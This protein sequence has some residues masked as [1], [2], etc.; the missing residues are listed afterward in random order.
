MTAL[1]WYETVPFGDGVSLIHEPWMQPYFRCNMWLIEGTERDLL[2]DSGMGIR[3]LRPALPRLAERPVTLLLSH[4]H[5]DH[6]G[7]ASEFETRLAHPAEAGILA[8]PDPDAILYGKYADGA[9]DAEMFYA[10]PEGWSAGAHRFE[11][12]PATGFVTEGDTI[13]LGNRVLRVLH[14]PGH[15]PGHLSLYEEK[16]GI[17]FAQDVVYDGPLV[18]RLYHSDIPTYR[19]TMRRLDELEPK[20]VHGGHFASFGRVRFHQLI[21]DYLAKTEGSEAG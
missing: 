16:T 10:P 17:L 13:D 9:R 6:I 21:V 1:D 5:F 15:S 7:S 2:I 8:D 18:D 11:A 12:A 3:P 20:I 4:S 14:T 19:R